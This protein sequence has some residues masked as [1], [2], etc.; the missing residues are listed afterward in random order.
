MRP[1]L[2]RAVGLALAGIGILGIACSSS[3]VLPQDAGHAPNALAFDVVVVGA[4]TGGAAAALAAARHGAKVLVV[5]PTG[6]IGGQMASVPLMDDAFL[7]GFVTTG[8]ADEIERK[9][10]AHYAAL[11][12]SV[13]TCYSLPST[14]CAEPHVIRDILAQTLAAAGVTVLLHTDVVSVQKT[15]DLVTGI[16]LSD[17]TIVS[18]KVLV[19]ATEYGDVLPLAGAEYRVGNQVSSRPIDPNACVQNITFVAPLQ[20]ITPRHFHPGRGAGVAPADVKT[21]SVI[22]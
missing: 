7:P 3:Q 15:G 14:V 20:R 2:S 8:F 22:T 11:G 17:D 10:V 6:W 18:S 16:T 1:I 13:H 9:V 19:D 4:G 21:R 5:E 12:K